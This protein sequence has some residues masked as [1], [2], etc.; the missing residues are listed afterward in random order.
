[1]TQNTLAS[2]VR[3]GARVNPDTGCW[4]W[5]GTRIGG[6]YASM[7]VS[8]RTRYVHRISYETFVGPIPQ[9]TELDHLC[10]VRHC[11][12]PE[13]LE[14]VSHR[15]NV[16]RGTSGAVNG[17]RQKAKTHCPAGHPYAGANLY[18]APSDGHRQ[19]RACTG[20]TIERG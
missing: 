10:R 5:S 6:G 13:H 20:R 17:A 3:E 4:E 8:D 15:E 14:P 11:V 9:G 16:R 1:M 18:L 12:N 2:R 7:S 19:C